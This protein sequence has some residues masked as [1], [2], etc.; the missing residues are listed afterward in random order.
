MLRSN[1]QT[2]HLVAAP[3]TTALCP[4]M[5]TGRYAVYLDEAKFFLNDTNRDL[6]WLLCAS[7]HLS[8][9][10]LHG[11]EQLPPEDEDSSQL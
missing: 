10:E 6:C 3:R 8:G 7:H 5:T 1:E 9:Q 2:Q 4:A 11:Q